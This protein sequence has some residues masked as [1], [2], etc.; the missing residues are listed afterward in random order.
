M[1]SELIGQQAS[2]RLPCAVE[3]TELLLGFIE[4]LLGVSGSEASEPEQLEQQMSAAVSALCD[5]AS[6]KATERELFA[7]LTILDESIEISL[8]HGNGE[9]GIAGAEA[10]TLTVREA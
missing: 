9:G 6:T 5:D 4:E 10:H 2:F 1:H 7:T 3:V 8:T